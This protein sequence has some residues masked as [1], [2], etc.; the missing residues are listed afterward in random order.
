MS[1]AL[2][3]GLDVLELL[4]ARGDSRVGD[5]MEDLGVSR[6]TAHRILGS[7][8]SRGYVEHVRDER[9]WRLGPAVTELAAGFDATSIM[10]LAAPAMAELRSTS[11]ETVNLAVVQRNRLVWAASFDGAYA[12]RFATT[13]GESVP[14]HCTAVGKA[15]LSALPPDR[16]AQFLPLE[17][18]PAH[19]AHTRRTTEALK[20]RVEAARRQGWAL[21]EEESELGGICVGAPILGRD[22]TPV[23][24]ISV[25]SAAARLPPDARAPLGRSVR[26]WCDQISFQLHGR[27]R[28]WTPGQ[29][30]DRHS[31]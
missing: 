1:D 31:A 28:S 21:D 30:G 7:L 24:A 29:D 25:S 9:L 8:Q 2:N 6:A 10:Q 16:W 19:T 14:I 4:A 23:A 15:V 12:L 20:P 22:G 27:V 11:R 5:V 17:P 26:K 3:R 13:V 18:F